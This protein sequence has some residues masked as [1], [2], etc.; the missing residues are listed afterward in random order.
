LN[1]PVT[2]SP[3]LYLLP[4]HNN[5]VL[6]DS[7]SAKT[8]ESEVDSMLKMCHVV[9]L[10]YDVNNYDIIKRLRTYW[11]PRIQK[12]NSIVPVIICGNK[13]DLRSSQQDEL[14][15]LLTPNFIDFSQVEMG[16]ECSAKGYMGLFDLISCV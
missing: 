14:E 2:I 8:A 11:L 3:D 15:S 6:V 12:V 5:T 13:I 7:S 1:A 9:V 4:N 16:I 10:V